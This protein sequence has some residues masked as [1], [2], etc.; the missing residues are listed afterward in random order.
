M[1]TTNRETALPAYD[2]RT[3]GSDFIGMV[4][5]RLHRKLAL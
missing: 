2:V 5:D 3:T 1:K 4:L